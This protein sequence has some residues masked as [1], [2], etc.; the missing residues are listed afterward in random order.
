MKAAKRKKKQTLQPWVY[1]NLIHRVFKERKYLNKISTR[2][3]K[4][5]DE[6]L[7]KKIMLIYNLNNRLKREYYQ[8]TLNENK[9][10]SEKLWKTLRNII[11]G[12]K[13]K[14]TIFHKV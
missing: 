7:K 3:T 1:E 12:N 8:K 10:E 5:L 6:V 14:V 2:S 9:Q 11:P 4:R 13:N